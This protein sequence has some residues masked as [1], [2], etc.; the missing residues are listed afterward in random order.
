MNTHDVHGREYAQLDKL[1]VGDKLE[2]DGDFTCM[3]GG[4]IKEVMRNKNGELYVKCS[5]DTQ[6]HYLCGQDDGNGYLVGMYL[7]K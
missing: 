3:H 7:I 5:L 6:E 2:V 1:N 4:D